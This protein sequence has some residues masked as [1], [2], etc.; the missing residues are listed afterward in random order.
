MRRDTTQLPMR[1]EATGLQL[2]RPPLLEVTKYSAKWADLD[3]L[4]KHKSV[5]KETLSMLCS[6]TPSKYQASGGCQVFPLVL[7]R[8]TVDG[9]NSEVLTTSLCQNSASR[10]VITPHSSQLAKMRSL[11]CSH[12]LTLLNGWSKGL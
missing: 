11:N 3:G 6:R 10:V 7:N 9:I 4:S 8:Q 12:L 5:K 1:K 2:N